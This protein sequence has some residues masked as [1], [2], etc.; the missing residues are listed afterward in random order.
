MRLLSSSFSLFSNSM[1]QPSLFPLMRKRVV[2]GMLGL[3]VVI[4]LA[5]LVHLVDTSGIFAVNAGTLE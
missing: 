5:L 2:W 1:L 4:A 3:A